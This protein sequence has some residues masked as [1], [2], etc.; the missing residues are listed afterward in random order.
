MLDHSSWEDV[1][2]L[3][4]RKGLRTPSRVPLRPCG[5]EVSL[6]VEHVRAS[7]ASNEKVNLVNA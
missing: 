5:V 4:T 1:L 2:Q 7:F 6:P 3:D